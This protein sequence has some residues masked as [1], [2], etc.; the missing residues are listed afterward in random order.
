M[1]ILENVQI[2][3]A[4]ARVDVLIF[5]G[6]THGRFSVKQAYNKATGHDAT[7]VNDPVW[8]WIWKKGTILPRI[9]MFLWKVMHGALPLAKI[10]H[11]RI[12]R[13][14]PNCLMCCQ[15]EED[16]MHM[17]FLCPFARACW[18]MGPLAIRTENLPSLLQNK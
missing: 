6:S 15:G 7:G 16:M 11:T 17:L 4:G 13:G 10:L 14:D 2:P 3:R 18:L 9:R 5:T 12:S 1:Y 8:K